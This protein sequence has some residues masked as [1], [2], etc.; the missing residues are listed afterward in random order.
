LE[1]ADSNT[2]LNVTS[3]GTPIVTTRPLRPDLAVVSTAVVGTGAGGI[4]PGT[5]LAKNSPIVKENKGKF[6]T[7]TE[8]DLAKLYE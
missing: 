7:A 3:D 5:V 1:Y 8:A 6:R 2:P 4:P